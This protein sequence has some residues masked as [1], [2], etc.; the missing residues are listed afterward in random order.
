MAKDY[1]THSP[2]AHTTHE[3]ISYK[4]FAWL[5]LF[6]CFFFCIYLLGTWHISIGRIFRMQCRRR[7]HYAW[8]GSLHSSRAQIISQSTCCCCCFLIHSI[9]IWFRVLVGLFFFSF[10]I[11][12][13]LCLNSLAFGF[14]SIWFVNLLI[15]II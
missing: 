4:M 3:L 15:I 6:F 11:Y 9:S 2:L 13:S 12:L 8:K 5:W 10:S 1:K 7:T 14:T